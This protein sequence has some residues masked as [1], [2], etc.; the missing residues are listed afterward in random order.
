MNYRIY[1]NDNGWILETITSSQKTMLEVAIYM[2][3]QE[4]S[5]L[6]IEHNKKTNSDFPIIRDL[7]S[8]LEYKENIKQK[9]MKKILKGE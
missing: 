9:S 1:V 7:A 6:I 5:F 8:Y 4:T 3:H 2:L